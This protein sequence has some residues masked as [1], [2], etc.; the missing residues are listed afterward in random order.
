MKKKKKHKAVA[1]IKY[2]YTFRTSNFDKLFL[3]PIWKRVYSE[4]NRHFFQGAWCTGKRT[5]SHKSCLVKKWWNINNVCLASFIIIKQCLDQLVVCSL[6]TFIFVD[7]MLSIL[8]KIFSR[9]FFIF[10][11]KQDLTSHANCL[12]WRQF[13]SN[14]DNLHEMSSP[15]FWG[16]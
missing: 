14:G 6:F 11:R 12:Q 13:V 2:C 7:L 16:K 1:V 9:Y 3:F 8:C 15:V 4:R 10:P 5:G